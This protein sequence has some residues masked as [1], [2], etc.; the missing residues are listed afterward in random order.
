MSLKK[1]SQKV[2]KNTPKSCILM[3]VGIFLAAFL[4]LPIWPKIDFPY[5]KFGRGT[6]CS[7]YFVHLANVVIERPLSTWCSSAKAKA[8]GESQF[9][10]IKVQPGRF[11]QILSKH[12]R[13]F[14]C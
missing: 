14:D 1:N 3:A 11:C 5:R 10:I 2:E 8:T 9:A 4:E 6:L 13:F 7:F 12:V